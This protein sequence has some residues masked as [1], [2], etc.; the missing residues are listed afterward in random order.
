MRSSK[1]IF[2]LGSV[3][4]GQLFATWPN[5]T[6]PNLLGADPPGPSQSSKGKPK[7]NL[8][9]DD[10]YNFSLYAPSNWDVDRPQNFAVPGLIRAAFSHQGGA[11]IVVFVQEPIRVDAPRTLL[12]ASAKTMKELLSA[13]IKRQELRQLAGKQAIWLEVEYA[14]NKGL[15]D[16]DNSINTTQH[17]VA[18]P[19]EKDVIVL[20]L[21]AATRSYAEHEKAFAEVLGSLRVG[22]ARGRTPEP[23]KSR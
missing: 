15:S 7:S 21:T 23:N 1:W 6:Q 11:S 22:D 20:L 14:G 17:W 13:K 3:L 16:D 2:I 18:I 4:L 19:R 10:Q 8:F 5:N 9:E 12:E